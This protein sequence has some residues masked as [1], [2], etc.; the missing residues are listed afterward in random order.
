MA[1]PGRLEVQ[2]DNG[3][4]D[5]CGRCACFDG[6]RMNLEVEFCE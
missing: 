3:S 1:S 5:A 4:V 2:Y 6:V